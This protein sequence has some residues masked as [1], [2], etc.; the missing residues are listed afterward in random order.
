MAHGVAQHRA[1][2]TGRELTFVRELCRKAQVGLSEMSCVFR[3]FLHRGNYILYGTTLSGS[4]K[5][6]SKG[7]HNI[8]FS[9]SPD[10]ECSRTS[11]VTPDK[12]YAHFRV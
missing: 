7:V 3:V 11:H 1:Q 4:G 5:V 10:L 2:H 12:V 6:M 9:V 8:A